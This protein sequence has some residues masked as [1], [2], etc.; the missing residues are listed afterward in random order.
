MAYKP[1]SDPAK[2]AKKKAAV[3]AR[4]QKKTV[5]TT[6]I[7]TEFLAYTAEPYQE[8]RREKWWPE[9]QKG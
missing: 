2:A 7:E 6:Q 4:I 9:R 3:E 8:Q 5:A 1:P